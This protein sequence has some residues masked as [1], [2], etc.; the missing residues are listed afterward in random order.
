MNLWTWTRGLRTRVHSHD[1]RI[2]LLPLPL[3]PPTFGRR[4]VQPRRKADG[5]R[6]T[7][8]HIK[9]C[10]QVKGKSYQHGGSPAAPG[11]RPEMTFLVWSKKGRDLT[12]HWTGGYVPVWIARRSV[13]LIS[14]WQKIRSCLF[15]SQVL[16]RNERQRRDGDRMRGKREG[17]GNKE[18][19]RRKKKYRNTATER[20]KREAGDVDCFF[21]ESRNS[22]FRII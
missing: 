21:E 2:L 16:T 5:W 4:Y 22:K 17:D 20:Q 18:K 14:R 11:W 7:M 9:W 19:Q 13:S 6:S 3:L 12:G 15:L 1:T 10:T 8:L